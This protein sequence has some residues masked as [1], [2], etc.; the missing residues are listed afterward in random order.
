MS[1]DIT[2]AFDFAQRIRFED[3]VVNNEKLNSSILENKQRLM[4][5]STSLEIGSKLTP[6]LYDCIIETCTNLKLDERHVRAFVY[7]EA[8]IQAS[9]MIGSD[10][11]CLIKISSG[12]VKSLKEKELMFIIGHELGHFLLSHQPRNLNDNDT[13][14]FKTSRAQEISAD[15]IGMMGC[16]SLESSVGAIIKTVSGL[17]EDYL[18]Y[19]VA[20]YMHHLRELLQ[21][22]SLDYE[23]F[24][25]HPPL[26]LR[27]KALLW[28]SMGKEF[29]SQNNPSDTDGYELSEVDSKVRSDLFKYV[30]SKV[31]TS[32]ADASLD[33]DFWL[34]SL[35]AVSDGRLDATERKDLSNRF[36][37]EMVEQ[38]VKYLK[39]FSKDEAVIEVSLKFNECFDRLS[40]KSKTKS[41]AILDKLVSDAESDTGRTDVLKLLRR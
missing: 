3:D 11:T 10:D 7:N 34:R 18:D 40:E 31:E 16:Q 24:A 38:L 23:I 9:C 4:F 30:D 32:I 8:D 33:V 21:S 2:S 29:K 15:R 1:V 17:T 12:A 20:A 41:M 35:I 5:L 22:E 27:A 25:T 36:G 37:E 14:V 26:P 28:F 13:E 6:S 39:M 19:D